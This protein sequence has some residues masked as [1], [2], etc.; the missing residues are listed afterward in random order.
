LEGYLYFTEY[1]EPDL[2]ASGLERLS[3]EIFE[4]D[5]EEKIWP[6]QRHYDH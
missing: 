6:K 3:C 2:Q 1:K 5:E 4:R